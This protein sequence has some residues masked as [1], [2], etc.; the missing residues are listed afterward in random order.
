[1]IYLYPAIIF[2]FDCS[3]H[4]KSLLDRHLQ[5]FMLNNKK[6]INTENSLTIVIYTLFSI[7]HDKKRLSLRFL[8]KMIVISMPLLL[9]I[10]MAFK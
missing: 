9:K 1:M 7:D 3:D 8:S 6:A 5:L 2:L 4:V 10:M